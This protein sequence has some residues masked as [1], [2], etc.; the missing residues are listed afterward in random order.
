[1]LGRVEG[2]GLQ[3][4]PGTVIGANSPAMKE[5]LHALLG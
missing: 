4:S 1:V 3:L 2:G 5:E